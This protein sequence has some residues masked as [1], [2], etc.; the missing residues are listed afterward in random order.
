MPDRTASNPLT[1]VRSIL[2][3]PILDEHKWSKIT[4]IPTDAVLLDLEDSV[5]PDRKDEARDR[6]TA[7]LARPDELPGKV[8]I[9]RANSLDSP[10]GE[11]DLRAL[12]RAGASVVAYPK[13]RDADELDRAAQ[14][15]NIEG[16]RTWLL[17]I[18]ETAAA[19]VHLEQLAARPDVAGFIFGPFDLAVDA[20]IT[21]LEG[22]GLFQD[23]YYYAKSKLVL[24]GAAYGLPV[25][26]MVAVRLLKDLASVEKAADH[27]QRL[28]FTG[29]ATF[30]PPHVPIINRS[31]TPPAS[32][33]AAAR[34]VVTA[35]EQSL[36]AGRAATQLDGEPVI[37]QDYKRA[38]RVLARARR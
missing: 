20:G 26:D 1:G 38:Q 30:Y 28:G 23:A 19:I 4:S 29:M 36:A 9:P 5:T 12:A 24:V 22:D 14:L 18:I 35:Y 37:V 2:E 8:Q 25:Y 10:Y 15:L 7:Q 27:A 33:I 13:V 17:P 31:F 6:V 3:S 16:R 32:A 21:A 11:N 34:R